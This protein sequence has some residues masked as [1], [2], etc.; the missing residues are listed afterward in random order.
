MGVLGTTLLVIGILALI[1]GSL[2]LI[3]PKWMMKFGKKWFFKNT[4]T[5]KKV[6]WIELVIAVIL[7][8]IGMNL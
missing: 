4:K 2:V 6:G 7:I 1:E 5:L 3:F 8:L